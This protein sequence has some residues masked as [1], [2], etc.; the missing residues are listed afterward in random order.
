MAQHDRPHD[1]DE[2]VRASLEHSEAFYK[3]LVESLPQ[4][5]FRKDRHGRLTFANTLYC[6]T[7]GRK[8]EDIVGKLDIEY[9]PA[10][11]AVKYM[12]DD[13][14]VMKTGQKLEVV[15]THP[16]PGGKL[17]YVQVI[18]TPVRDAGGDIIGIQG[19]FWD[20]T[21]RKVMEDEL[22]YERE[23]LR[24]LLDTC[25]DAIYFKDMESRFLKINRTL[26]ERIGVTDPAD[27]I[28]KM[29]SDFFGADHSREALEDEARVIRTGEPLISKLE[30]E[31]VPGRPT[32]WIITTKVP[33][34]DKEGKIVGT[35]GISRDVSELKRAEQEIAVARDQAIE[36]AR[37]KAE[38][39][40]NMSHEIR[41]PL[42]A[43]VGMSHLLLDT[44][45]DPE[46]RDFTSTIQTSADVLLNIVNDILD[47]SKIEA[48]KMS[49]ERI[50]FDVAQILEEAADL[51]AERA[52]SKGLELVVWIP[53]DTPTLLAGDPS[54][55][56]QVLVNL[57]SNAVKF[58]EK[59]EV[60]VQAEAM[61]ADDQDVTLKFSVRDT[62]IGVAEEAH[63]RLFS[64]FTQA[65]GS[66]T[67]RYGG[68]GLGLAISKNLV[69]L[70]GGDI[71]FDSKVGEGSTFWFTL[72]LGRGGS[73]LR[74]RVSSDAPLAGLHVLIVDDNETNR[75][76]LRRQTSAWR[77]RSEAAVSGPDA[78]RQLRAAAESSDP[79]Q[80]VLLDMQM[81]DMDGMS[82]A[83][84]I[85]ADPVLRTT[86]LVVLTS[87]AHHPEEGDHKRIGISAY[88]TKPVKQSRLFDVLASVMDRRDAVEAQRAAATP[89]RV[90]TKAP[91]TISPLKIL[92]AEDNA[93]NQKVALRQLARLGYTADAV[94]SGVEALA[95]LNRVNYDVILMDCQMPEMDGY[96]ATRRIRKL[97]AEHPG[98]RHY[99]I[100]LTANALD[101]DRAKCLAAGMDD[102][103]S[104]PIR[105]ENLAQAL[106]K[107]PDPLN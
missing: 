65:D 39:L 106:E 49:I 69:A 45:L 91:D 20:V 96:E 18:K 28:G 62:G 97:E 98:R 36:T 71:G 83:R 8:L 99:I 72:T 2:N 42:N 67:R 35:F 68:T 31:E 16:Q 57:V 61:R 47:F 92:M 80:L 87:L 44:Q 22:H 13:Q 51:L 60:V 50:D 53:P 27:A 6:K 107:R 101:G 54:R 11:A 14:N 73:Q 29:D 33:L 52:Q 12:A 75:E 58:T 3:T 84:A 46:Q 1:S 15:E 24:T 21:E 93:V 85:K 37:F 30:L 17:M 95:A 64:A 43:I 10:E 104:K 38:F 59:G 105:L 25:P 88:L 34:R 102:Y 26:A 63:S 81:P 66:T 19:I 94:A 7:V 4:S 89:K 100:A 40:A 77:M 79:F 9:L 55:I 70:M 41:T 32:N 86:Q 103:L 23:L 90:P 78:L 82:V 48:G 74:P 76:I 56:R 5:F